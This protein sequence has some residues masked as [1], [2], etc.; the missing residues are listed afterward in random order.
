MLHQPPEPRRP[1][2]TDSAV[3]H[4]ALANDAENVALVR[5]V[6]GGVAEAVG[7]SERLTADVKTAVSEACGNVVLHA[8]GNARGPMLVSL[9][10]KRTGVTV[11]VRDRGGG[12]RP[13]KIDEERRVLGVG[14]SLIQAL[15]DSAELRDGK[16]GTEV[17]MGFHP[18]HEGNL[19]APGT[20]AEGLL[21]DEPQDPSGEAIVAVSSRSL[22]A[23]AL[24]A[25][26]AVL[27]SRA[28]FSVDRL[29]DAQLI[30][31]TIAAHA[32]GVVPGTYLM[33]G[34]ESAERRLDLHLGPLAQGGVEQLLAAT[35]VGDI[36]PLE[37]LA[38]EIATEREDGRE[39]LRLRLNA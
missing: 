32:D 1:E 22:A 39:Y 20:L 25:T 7:M 4:L 16:Q 17:R 8:Y 24:G 30:T 27:A 10:V 34:V 37:V 26:V 19:N 21:D 38:D 29:S 13:H 18:E 2:M 28:S 35:T 3:V 15:S 6:I 23:A 9:G 12:I 14:L 11:I 33:L 31:D 5:H 36:R